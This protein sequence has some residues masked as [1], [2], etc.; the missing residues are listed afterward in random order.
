MRILIRNEKMATNN[1]TWVSKNILWKIPF[2]KKK[3][4]LPRDAHHSSSIR[5][6]KKN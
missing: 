5:K 2:K 1:L 3:L 4:N 6:L